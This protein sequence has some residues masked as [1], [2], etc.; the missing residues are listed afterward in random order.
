MKLR[1]ATY[2]EPQSGARLKKQFTLHGLDGQSSSENGTAENE[3]SPLLASS[4]A[5]RPQTRLSRLWTKCKDTAHNGQKFAVSD[6]G[7]GVLKCALAYLLG[8]M[9]TFIP[10]LSSLFGKQNSKHLVATITVYFHPARTMGSM[11]DALILAFTA[12]LYTAFVSV[13]SMSVSV[14]FADVLDLIAVGHAVILI[15]FIGGGLGFVGWVKLVKGD[16]LVNIACSLTSLS[17]ITVL[18][19]EGAVQAGDYSFAKI[20]QILNMIIAGVIATMAVSFLVYPASGRQNLKQNMIDV[21]DSL[22]DMLALITSSFLTGDESELD[23]RPFKKASGRHQKTFVTLGKNLKEAQYEHYFLGTERQYHVEAKL[24]HCVQRITQ[25][26]GGLRSAAAMQFVVVKLPNSFM[27]RQGSRD[28]NSFGNSSGILQRLPG[29]SR[30]SSASYFAAP[31]LPSIAETPNEDSSSPQCG[32]GESSE[33]DYT[34]ASEIFELF[35]DYLGPS[36]RSLAFTMKEILDELP[37]DPDQGYAITFNPRFKASMDRALEMYKTAREEALKIIYEKKQASKSHSLELDADWEEAAASCGHFSFSLLE[38]AEQI[39]EYLV[40]L[41]QMQLEIEEAP[42]GR[43]WSW[44]KFWRSI[45]NA[46]RLSNIDSDLAAIVEHADH[47]DLHINMPTPK[48]TKLRKEIAHRHSKSPIKEKFFRKLYR[49]MAFLRY[50][51]TKFAIK[52]GFGAALYALP[53]FIPETRPIYSHWRG[54]WGLLSYMLVC[55][56]TVGASNTTGYSRVL[57]TALGAILACAAW[58]ISD[59]NPFLLALF[60]FLMAYWTAYIIVGLGKGPMG[61]FIMLTYN[62]SALYAYSLSVNDEGTGDDSDGDE[63][64]SQRKPL[65]FSIAS[66]RFVAV[67][68]GVIWGLII[69]RLVWPISARQKLK[70]GL[71]LIWLRMGLIWKRDPL[72][73]FLEGENETATSHQYMNLREEFQLQRFLAKLEALIESAKSEFELRGPFPKKEYS[74]IL[75]STG[76]MLDAFHAMNVV[77]LK[78]LHASPGEESLL[79]ATLRERALL[80]ARISHLFSILA[81]SMKLEY[82]VAPDASP[83]ID[84]RREALLARIFEYRAEMESAD[85]EMKD[86]D[87]G[88]L[89]TF[90]LVTGQLGL[91]IRGVL[92]TVEALF[93]VLDEEVLMLQ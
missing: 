24:V 23:D 91:E 71:S 19:K 78:D 83:G 9:A 75:K 62:L 8:S 16:P 38:V 57:G 30:K 49:S 45:G 76:R 77:I 86:E 15:V 52:V 56:M 89:Y 14:F 31:I 1:Q 37:Y 12:F 46:E 65:I 39:S 29:P 10:G 41:D 53:A 48:E 7:K 55:S 4:S 50:D 70:D 28:F 90:A 87:F 35:I 13:I 79:R 42:T 80:C 84:H 32:N 44:L 81:S 64:D 47:L 21:T 34:T 73:L 33:D 3:S 59:A 74:A 93:G 85:Q 40:I 36:M 58:E 20:A 27:I 2:I 66:H 68:S 69:T 17:L 6:T 67:L 25:S 22:A 88:L 82:L 26:I 43:T 92:E 5:F 63:E 18:T 61:R 11:F 60:G 72:A 51:D 54:E